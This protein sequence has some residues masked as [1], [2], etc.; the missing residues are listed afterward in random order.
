MDGPMQSVMW[1][2]PDS[3]RFGVTGA[4]NPILLIS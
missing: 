1:R 3:D 2:F 4:Y